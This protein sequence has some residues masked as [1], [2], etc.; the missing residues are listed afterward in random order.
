MT[1]TLSRITQIFVFNVKKLA[2][3]VYEAEMKLSQLITSA[4]INLATEEGEDDSEAEL[5]IEESSPGLE[6]ATRYDIR[7]GH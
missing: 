7:S 6:A 4:E 2:L 5:K 3:I 1:H